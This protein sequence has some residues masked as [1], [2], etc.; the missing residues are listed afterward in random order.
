MV[1]EI[2]SNAEAASLKSR[3]IVWLLRL[4][5]KKKSLA[6]AAVVQEHV[7]QL[8][9]HPASYEPV[10]L[11]PGVSVNLEIESGWPVYHITPLTNPKTSNC[12]VFLHG[13]GY[14]NEIVKA[15]W[16][17]IGQLTREAN[18]HCIVPIYPVA[19]KGT[20]DVVVPTIGKFLQQLL[21]DP[22]IQK[23]TL[24][25][26]SAGAGMSLAAAQWL[27]DARS[28]QPDQLVL[29]SPGIDAS[30]N[31]PGHLAAASVDPLLDIP[32][33]KEGARL[34]AGELDTAH[35]YISPLNGEMHG[36]AP[37]LIFAG[38]LDLLYPDSMILAAKARNAGV[39]VQLHLRKGQPHNYA[40]M[41][42]PE[43]KQAQDIIIKA[44]AQSKAH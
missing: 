20:A 38:K 36:L 4:F 41:S 10:G 13:G 26:N 19:P 14:I 30:L 11:G 44:V 40:A 31:K 15:H 22:A 33:I 3:V 43:G 18:V 17:F 39:P 28:P 21:N 27:R 12:V 8:A 1:K 32:G 37:M 7:R 5:N 29:I 6:S 23:I 16:A 2:P 9:I 34:Y 35:P 24:M 25:G 42:T